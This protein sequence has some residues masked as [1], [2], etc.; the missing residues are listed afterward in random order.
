MSAS[1]P[2]LTRSNLMCSR[3]GPGMKC[4]DVGMEHDPRSQN[5][6]NLIPRT[7]MREGSTHVTQL[8][9]FHPRF[10]EKDHPIVTTFGSSSIN[11]LVQS[12][13]TSW[14]GANPPPPPLHMCTWY[15]IRWNNYWTKVFWAVAMFLDPLFQLMG[16]TCVV[17]SQFS[18]F[19]TGQ[20]IHLIINYIFYQHWVS[21]LL[22]SYKTLLLS[23]F[24]KYSLCKLI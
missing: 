20:I 17:L 9:G 1:Q 15:F 23:Y 4:L 18:S 8:L 12:I 21:S 11:M 24:M 19:N 6:P 10:T 7:T 22:G 3:C 14:C 16:Q 13:V 2:W 5:S